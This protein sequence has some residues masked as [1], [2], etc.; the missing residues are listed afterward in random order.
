[1]DSMLFVLRCGQTILLLILEPNGI[2]SVAAAAALAASAPAAATLWA[3][4]APAVAYAVLSTTA[5][6]LWG[7]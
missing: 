4:S 6:V 7:C 2:A 5:A 1:M 3:L